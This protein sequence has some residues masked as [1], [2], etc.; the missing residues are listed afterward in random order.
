MTEPRWLDAEQQRAWRSLIDGFALLSNALEKGLRRRFGIGMGEYEVLVRLSERENHAMRMAELAEG[1]VMSRSRLTHVVARMEERGFL[2]RS[3]VVE[4]GRGVLCSMT[5]AGW[6]LLREAA[7][8]HVED[9]RADLMDLIDKQQ[10]EALATT[11]E[12]VI[13]HLR[14]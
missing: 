1:T 12:A 2:E 5:E 7:P 10:T 4:D 13:D 14:G 8:H 9:V 6:S 11:F 3:Q